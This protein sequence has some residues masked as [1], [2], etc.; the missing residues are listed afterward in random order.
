MKKII[1]LTESEL[2][3]VV[4]KIISENDSMDDLIHRTL[5]SGF[6]S[7][8][9]RDSEPI[10][11]ILSKYINSG[12]VSYKKISNFLIFDV[13]SPTDFEVCGFSKSDAVKVKSKLR[14]N[15]FNSWGVGQYAK[16]IS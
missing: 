9:P 15:G 13:G 16:Q 1:R 5:Y 8:T 6:K 2:I 3:G 10:F 7:E 11:D 14:D 12:C 4:K